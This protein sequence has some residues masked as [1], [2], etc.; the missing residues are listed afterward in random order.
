M[1]TGS[2]H[3][4]SDPVRPYGQTMMTTPSSVMITMIPRPR[5]R[6]MI[7]HSVFITSRRA[8]PVCRGVEPRHIG[9]PAI[10]HQPHPW[11]GISLLRSSWH[12]P[13]STFHVSSE[14]R[15]MHISSQNMTKQGK[16]CGIRENRSRPHIGKGRNQGMHHEN[17]YSDTERTDVPTTYTYSHGQRD[18][19]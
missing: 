3:G 9:L 4:G 5:Q 10:R 13:I 12:R 16:S 14:V 7:K 8:V 11:S 19:R 2:V 17:P 6:P 1:T 15:K 18:N